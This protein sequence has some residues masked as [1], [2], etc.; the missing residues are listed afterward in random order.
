MPPMVIL[1]LQFQHPEGLQ[2]V[3]VFVDPLRRERSSRLHLS[4]DDGFAELL[5][6]ERFFGHETPP[7]VL[8]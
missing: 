1:A 2:A 4:R 6:F 3:F 8:Y 7:F 5:E